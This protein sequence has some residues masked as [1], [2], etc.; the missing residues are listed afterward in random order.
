MY[1][2][3]RLNKLKSMGQVSARGAHNER[4]RATPNADGERLHTNERLAGSGAWLADVQARLDDAPTIRKNAV[5][6]YDV[7]FTASRE[8]FDAGDERAR[9]ERLAEWR[10]RTMA[11][12]RARFGVENVVAAVLHR[13]EITP[14]IQ[15]LV[16]PIDDNGRLNARG[17]G[18]D[19]HRNRIVR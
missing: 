4:T 8:F 18:A 7:V 12:L 16:V 11:W 19:Y 6:A 9:D 14:H 17:L 13:D 5:L 15:A 3:M 2:V 1:A 10:D